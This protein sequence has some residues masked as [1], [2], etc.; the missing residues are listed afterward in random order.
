M[1]LVSSDITEKK[2]SVQSNHVKSKSSG[3]D[4]SYFYSYISRGQIL[5]FFK[6]KYISS[7]EILLTVQTLMKCSERGI[8]SVSFCGISSGS[9]LFAKGTV[10]RSPV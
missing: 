6:L 5:D 8:S 1:P 9:A 3:L 2:M 7:L 4:F 10:Y